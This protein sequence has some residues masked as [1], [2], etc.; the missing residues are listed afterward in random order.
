[1]LEGVTLPAVR[2][3]LSKHFDDVGSV[4]T[5]SERAGWY[6][7][8]LLKLGAA[9]GLPTLSQYFIIWDLDMIPL[10]SFSLTIASPSS[11]GGVPATR[12]D[13]STVRISEYAH[14]YRH[15]LSPRR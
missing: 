10:P 2:S 13:I 1:M 15:T 5:A 11:F 7:Q 6:F 4:K 14:A 3:H 9:R 8:Q 12:A